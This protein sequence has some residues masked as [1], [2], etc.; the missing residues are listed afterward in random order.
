MLFREVTAWS[1]DTTSQYPKATES[2]KPFTQGFS[3]ITRPWVP[4]GINFDA[5]VPA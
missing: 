5:D 3:S 2:D 4:K 1:K